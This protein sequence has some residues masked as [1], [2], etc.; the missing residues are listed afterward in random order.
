MRTWQMRFFDLIKFITGTY[1][2]M[3]VISLQGEACQCHIFKNQQN[4]RRESTRYQCRET[5]GKISSCYFCSIHLWFTFSCI[6]DFAR[7]GLKHLVVTFTIVPVSITGLADLSPGQ[8]VNRSSSCDRTTI[9]FPQ[10]ADFHN[11]LLRYETKE[12]TFQNNE[13]VN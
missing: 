11:H 8:I 12:H 13:I 2:L 1:R 5:K 7:W 6:F 3:C 9:N 10:C 4:F